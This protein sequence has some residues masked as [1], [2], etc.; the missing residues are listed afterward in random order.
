MI[1]KI[2]SNLSCLDSPFYINVA[3]FHLPKP[4][5][6]LIESLNELPIIRVDLP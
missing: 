2:R 6:S 1:Y 4:T 3:W 5:S